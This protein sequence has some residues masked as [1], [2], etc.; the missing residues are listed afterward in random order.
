MDNNKYLPITLDN[1]KENEKY[2]DD[3]YYKYYLNCNINDRRI[4]CNILQFLVECQKN[5]INLDDSFIVYIGEI[6]TVCLNIIKKLFPNIM[7]LLYTRNLFILNND[8]N[9]FIFKNY[10][11]DYDDIE[12]T[13][14]LFKNSDKKNFLYI[15][16]I[17][18][19]NNYFI[20]SLIKQQELLL[21]LNC[22]ASCLKLKFPEYIEKNNEEYKKIN[23][24]DNKISYLDGKIFFQPYT[25][26]NS[27]ETILIS[28]EPFKNKIYDILE[29]EK[30]MKIFN[31]NIKNN[32]YTYK[33]SEKYVFINTYDEILEYY[34]M[35]NY[36]KIN[37]KF[38][39][40]FDFY[41]MI[42][43]T[44]KS[45]NLSNNVACKIK[46]FV[47]S[48]KKILNDTNFSNNEKEK[49]I[50]FLIYTVE[51]IIK[52]INNFKNNDNNF[53]NLDLHIDE[54]YIKQNYNNDLYVNKEEIDDMMNYYFQ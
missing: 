12:K 32:E 38:D 37:K 24:V 41:N 31:L 2:V 6:S 28:F 14:L 18:F 36:N 42:N 47:H 49:N 20:N 23:I 15:S 4:F 29:Y 19:N 8:D 34:I 54:Y 13:I 39:N 51:K 1:L 22:K 25:S 48:I 40:M 30:K 33:N 3:N 17:D 43:L 52:Q 45:Y 10:Y 7:W 53:K 46:L 27:L 21:I 50:L 16:D 9:N 44:F 35:Y 26:K 11:L 5:N